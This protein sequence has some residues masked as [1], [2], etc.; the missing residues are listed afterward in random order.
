MILIMLIMTMIMMV[1]MT[2]MKV[3]RNWMWSLVSILKKKKNLFSILH[4]APTSNLRLL[5]PFATKKYFFLYFLS[6]PKFVKNLANLLLCEPKVSFF[7]Y[8][9]MFGWGLKGRDYLWCVLWKRGIWNFIVAPSGESVFSKCFQPSGKSVFSKCF[10]E[11]MLSANIA[12]LL[13]LLSWF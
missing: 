8:I 13:P 6:L 11:K 2:K 10:Q 5:Q 1:I 3:G 9:H 7:K 12:R 4:K